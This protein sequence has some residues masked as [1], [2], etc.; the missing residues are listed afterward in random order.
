MFPNA[1]YIPR[2]GQINAWDNDEFVKAVKATGRRQLIIAGMVTDV[3]A[4]F[5]TLSALEAG[6][7]VF[8]LTDASGTFNTAVRGSPGRGW[9]TRAR[10][11]VDCACD[12]L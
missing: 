1:P 3:C 7:E 10:R 8:V 5:V 9:P 11:A 12:R 2:P 4:A 6:Y